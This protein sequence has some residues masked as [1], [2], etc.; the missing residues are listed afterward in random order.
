MDR[1][2]PLHLQLNPSKIRDIT[3]HLCTTAEVKFYL[4]NLLESSRSANYLKPNKNCNLTS[5]VSGCEPGWACSVSC[6]KTDLRNLKE[7]PARTSNCQSCCEGF[8][9][10][11]KPVSNTFI[12][13]GSGNIVL[14]AC[15]L[16]SH[17]SL[18]AVDLCLGCFKLSSC[19]SNTATQNMQAYGI[20]LIIV[21]G[22]Y[23]C[24]DPVLTTR[25]RRMTKSRDAAARNARKTANARQ[26]WKSAKDVKKTEER[27]NVHLSLSLLAR[28][29]LDQ[30]PHTL[31][32]HHA[33]A[34]L[35]LT[36]KAATTT[37]FFSLL[38]QLLFA[39]LLNGA[40]H[41]WL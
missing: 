25:E 8:V 3:K 31:P 29:E 37:T 32:P 17:C 36:G 6:Q 15:P 20:L 13:F 40:C 22:I 14:E 1:Y 38:D 41:Q 18:V 35:A 5:W 39:L 28:L 10:T 16:G 7:I 33:T 2:Y 34:Y 21:G 27:A 30:R 4:N 26:R 24:S 11:L 19:D 12:F 9:F 23:N